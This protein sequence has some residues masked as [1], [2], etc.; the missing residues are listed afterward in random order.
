MKIFAYGI[1][2]DEKPSL[3]KWEAA[4][5]NVE[6][7]YTDNILTADSARL[8]EGCDG[9]VTLQTAPYTREALEVLSKLGVHNI[10]IRNVGFDNFDFKDLNDLGFTLTNVPVYSPNAIAEHTV[11][12][13]GRLLRRV[14][15][16]DEKF[17][18]GDFTWAPT[19]G[20]EY[21]EQTVGVIGTGHIGRV[22]IQILQG[23]GA[24]VVAYDVYHNPEIEKQGL[25]V[26]S[27]EELYK[28]ADII[29][30]HVPLFDSNKYMINDKAIAQM[31]NG[32][33]IINCARGELIDTDALIKGLDSGKI[34]GAGL[35]VL[36]NENAV[37]GKVWSS[38]DN[39]PDAKIK[40]LAKR[41]NVIITPHSAFYTETA[42][43]NMI[44]TA[45]DS[46]KALNQGE[47]PHNIVDTNPNK[48]AE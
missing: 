24:K 26:D 20:K 25:Y 1:R 46:N 22:V 39:I 15:E 31:K 23:F 28:Q 32:V 21:R 48:V 36:D 13:M 45:F 42:I 33:Y 10:S 16:F 5:P 12:L 40:N 6:V 17:D 30:L 18:H 38:V 3:K 34:A 9:V 14:P 7:G 44:T 11:L 27:L 8:A 4:N 47:K 35:D 19:I 29:T 41:T 2:E 43:Y 37:F